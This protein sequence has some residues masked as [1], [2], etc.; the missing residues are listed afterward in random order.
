MIHFPV[1]FAL[2]L[3]VLLWGAGAAMLSMPAPWRRFWPVAVMPWGWA[4]QSAVVWAGAHA[5]WRG[6]DAYAWAMQALPVALLAAG[7]LRLGVV[8]AG[9]DL[10]RWGLVWALVAA[11]LM[12]AVL[13][14]ALASRE[15]TTLSLGS[16][17]AADYAAGARVLQ[18]FARGERGG[19]LGLSEVV[20]VQSVDNFF[21]YWLRLNHFTPSALIAFNGTILGCA[22]HQVI[23]VFVAVLLAGTLPL[24]FWLARALVGHS[25]V[26][27]LLVAGLYGLS[28]VPWYAVA[29]V[30]PGQMLAAQ[31][32]GLLTWIGIALWR[33][34][35]TWRRGWACAWLLGAAYWILL[36]SY[37]FFVLVCLVPA[38]A[39]AGGRA[40][41]ERRWS[42]LACWLLLMVVPLAATAGLFWGRVAG[43]A[44]RLTLLRAYDFGWKVPMLTPEGW[45]GLVSTA[46]LSPW[47]F[48]VVRWGMAGALT[49]LLVWI[50]LRELRRNGRVA[51]LLVALLAPVIL[52]YAA[53][54]ARGAL[55]GTNASYDAYKV[56]AVFQPVLLPALCWWASLRW[57]RRLSDWLVVAVAGS[58]VVAGTLVSCAWFVRDL[59]RAPLRVD[60]ELPQLRRIEGMA[61]VDSVNLVFAEPDMWSRLWANVFLLRKGQYFLTDTYEGRWRT[62]LRAAWDLEATRVSL[63]LTGGARRLVTSRFALVDT[64]SPAFVRVLPVEGVYPEEHD[65]QGGRWQWTSGDVVLQVQ[66]PNLAAVSCDLR[67]VGWS[68]EPR[69]VSVVGPDLV[70]AGTAQVG[71]ERGEHALGTVVV[72]PGNSKVRIRFDPAARAVPG[73]GRALAVAVERLHVTP[74]P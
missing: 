71:R 51:W 74:R 33:G 55:L 31:A 39:Y 24:V 57:S 58:V 12:V 7:L 18:E 3:H 13:P 22:P 62:P 44:E 69:L 52:A 70:V 53:L 56:F 67:L 17:D 38:V 54:Q 36:G 65:N 6:T 5:G 2:L 11:C 27:S 35:L 73:D 4:L 1:A 66:N 45:L 72:P 50:M 60:P 32:V 59:S 14:A 8:R 21:D 63:D 20:R 29:H 49:G 30:A 23:T 25:A 15:L 48:P 34:R 26:V 43:L 16:C 28:P 46:D 41:F 61:D 47:P 9:R 37:N 19:F 10:A 68:P 40:W 64:R 42:R